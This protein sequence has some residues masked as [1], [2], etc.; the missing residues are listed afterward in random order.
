MTREELMKALE[1]QEEV[2]QFVHFSNEDA[3][4]LGNLLVKEA[5]R[6]GISIAVQIRRNNNMNIFTYAMPGITGYNMERLLRK[7]NTVQMMEKSSLYMYMLLQES[8]EGV[9]GLQ[10]PLNDFGFYGGAFP[11]RIE[12]A[13][14][15]G[16]VAISGIGHVADHDF[17]IKTIS[18]YLH[19]DEVP[20]ISTDK[21]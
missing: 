5:K 18:K 8:K 10:L 16:S 3:W 13:G 9:Q 12:E 1:M 21:M 14:V 17:L 4:E 7:H 11:I 15:I 19:I 2:L 6:L 20:R